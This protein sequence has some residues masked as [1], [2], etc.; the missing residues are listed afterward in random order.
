MAKF[1]CSQWNTDILFVRN[2]AFHS[3]ATDDLDAL[4]QNA[5]VGMATGNPVG[6]EHYVNVGLGTD[7]PILT[8]IAA[9]ISFERKRDCRPR[10]LLNQSR[11][12]PISGFLCAGPMA[13]I[14]ARNSLCPSIFPAAKAAPRAGFAS[15]YLVERV[16]HYVAAFQVRV[17]G[18][19]PFLAP[20][21]RKWFPSETISRR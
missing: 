15:K 18:C 20:H 19:W 12:R 10:H 5:V 2:F 7:R 8:C 21:R 13:I 6:I 14:L 9:I 11:M 1:A 4:S 3:A 16:L 17:C